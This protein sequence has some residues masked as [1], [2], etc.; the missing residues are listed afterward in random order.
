MGRPSG[1]KNIDL[2]TGANQA[3][4]DG[5]VHWKLAQRFNLDVMRNH[6]YDASQ[7]DTGMMHGSQGI[8]SYW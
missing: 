8:I 4:A 7:T 2:L 5:S 1:S 6:T 3:L